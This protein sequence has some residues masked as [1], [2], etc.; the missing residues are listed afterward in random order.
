[1]DIQ[2]SRFPNNSLSSFLN[3]LFPAA[4]TDTFPLLNVE[5]FKILLIHSIMHFEPKLEVGNSELDNGMHIHLKTSLGL[6]ASNM[7]VLSM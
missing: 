1:M 5:L 4:A 2:F 3:K 7:Y 6:G